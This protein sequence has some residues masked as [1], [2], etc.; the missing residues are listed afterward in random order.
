MKW[1]L[2]SEKFPEVGQPVVVWKCKDMDGYYTGP[3]IASYFKSDGLGGCFYIKDSCRNPPD[4]KNNFR[5]ISEF[6]H[7]MILPI[8]NQPE[9]L[10]EETPEKVM[11]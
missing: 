8:P 11:R 1:I 4:T 5:P 2:L 6:S 3:H 9:R 10:S 7:W